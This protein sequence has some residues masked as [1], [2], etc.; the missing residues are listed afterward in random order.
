MP[1]ALSTGGDGVT[2]D[3]VVT[4]Y[5]VLHYQHTAEDHTIG[6]TPIITL[7]PASTHQDLYW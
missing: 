7:V 5:A 3:P 4:A 6:P 1:V 2:E